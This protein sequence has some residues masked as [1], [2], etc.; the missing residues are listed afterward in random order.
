MRHLGLLL[1]VLSISTAALAQEFRASVA[2]QVTDS[3][4]A[5]V[6]GAD[7][8]I[9]SIE[10]NTS[11]HTLSNSAGRYVIEFLLPGHYAL[12][13]EKS[14]FKKYVRTGINRESADHLGLN[15]A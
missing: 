5:I 2:G 9:V 12:T 1:S 13:V 15:V 11:A 4:G 14:G 7:V 6:P 8:A 10:R 3:S